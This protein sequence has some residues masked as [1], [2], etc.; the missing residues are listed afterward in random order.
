[1]TYWIPL[2]VGS[3]K[4]CQALVDVLATF[5]MATFPTTSLLFLLRVRAIYAGHKWITAFFV[6]CWL[7]LTGL[8]IPLPFS[9]FGSRIGMTS[10]CIDTGGNII[11]PAPIIASAVFDSFVFLFISWRLLNNSMTGDSLSEK[12]KAFWSKDGLPALSR[13]LLYSGQVYYL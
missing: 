4:N 10:H 7:A 13:A 2:S 3:I 9:L 1:M 12:M 11:S 8:A 5:Y 6:I